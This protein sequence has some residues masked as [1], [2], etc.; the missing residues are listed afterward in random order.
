MVGR[1]EWENRKKE[2]DEQ[3]KRKGWTGKEKGLG[4]TDFGHAI[5]GKHSRKQQQ[6]SRLDILAELHLLGY[7]T[8]Q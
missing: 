5:P 7:A 3:E 4:R 2:K 1:D 6:H 8:A